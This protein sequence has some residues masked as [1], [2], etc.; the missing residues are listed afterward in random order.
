MNVEEKTRVNLLMERKMCQ[1]QLYLLIIFNF[2]LKALKKY[3]SNIITNI[4]RALATF[5]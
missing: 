2:F 3:L 1:G 4:A 5:E